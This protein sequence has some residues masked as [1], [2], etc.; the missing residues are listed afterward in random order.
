MELDLCAEWNHKSSK[1]CM[2][3]MFKISCHQQ[4]LVDH[5]D[6]SHFLVR[7]IPSLTFMYPPWERSAVVRPSDSPQDDFANAAR[8]RLLS[9]RKRDEEEKEATARKFDEVW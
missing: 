1:K 4:I 8:Q 9:K 2:R 5:Q 6:D 7:G 3:D